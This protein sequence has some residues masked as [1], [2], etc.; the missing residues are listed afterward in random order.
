[1]QPQSRW[2]RDRVTLFFQ[3]PV[4]N[5]PKRL[6]RIRFNKLCR[7]ICLLR[8]IIPSMPATLMPS[9][10]FWTGTID[11]A[12]DVPRKRSRKAASEPGSYFGIGAAGF[13]PP[14]NGAGMDCVCFFAPSVTTCPSSDGKHASSSKYGDS[15]LELHRLSI[16]LPSGKPKNLN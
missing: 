5:N 9:A 12:D 7:D 4:P 15:S 11:V 16:I 8:S 14:M 1:M 2:W 13:G 10:S 6:I 3:K